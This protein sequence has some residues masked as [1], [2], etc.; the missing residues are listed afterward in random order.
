MY[1]L[2]LLLVIFSFYHII[3]YHVSNYQTSN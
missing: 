2:L 1:V 3:S